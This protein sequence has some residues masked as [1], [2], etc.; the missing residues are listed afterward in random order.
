[1]IKK[2]LSLTYTY[3]GIAKHIRTPVELFSEVYNEA[4]SL[5]TTALWDTGATFS[6]IT[7]EIAKKLKLKTLDKA[8]IFGVNSKHNVDMVVVSVVFPNNISIKD[9]RVAVCNITPTTNMIIG[10]DVIS[11]MDF[12]ICNGNSQTQFSFAKPPFK[13]KVDFQNW[14]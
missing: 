4:I 9:L 7:P 2:H 10:M 3:N 5:T 1:M 13:N 11:Q 8:R 14:S 12:A 6:A